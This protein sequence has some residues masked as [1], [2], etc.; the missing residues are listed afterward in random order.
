ME[1]SVSKTFAVKVSAD[2]DFEKIAR[3][4]MVRTYSNGV[5]RAYR[6]DQTPGS[7]TCMSFADSESYHLP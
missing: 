1:L 2:G 5:Y 6:L 7:S 3:I 4:C